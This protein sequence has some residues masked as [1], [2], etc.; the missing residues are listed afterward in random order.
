MR[1]LISNIFRDGNLNFWHVPSMKR[2]FNLTEEDN[3]IL[4]MDFNST[5]QQ[6]ATGGKDCNIR[7]YDECKLNFMQKPKA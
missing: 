6:F 7:I 4:C 2:I 3:S 5:G 1:I